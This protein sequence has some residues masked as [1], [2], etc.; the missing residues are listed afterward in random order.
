MVK[1]VN[2]SLRQ[3]TRPRNDSFTPDGP[4]AAD[5]PETAD[6]ASGVKGE[7]KRGKSFF[8]YFLCKVVFIVT[9]GSIASSLTVLSLV[10]RFG[11]KRLLND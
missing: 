7:Q 1:R 8:I 5:T 4:S 10:R 9:P 3:Q 11:Q 6:G 2:V